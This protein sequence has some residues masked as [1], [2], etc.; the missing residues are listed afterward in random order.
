MQSQGVTRYFKFLDMLEAK[1][2]KRI[3]RE[4]YERRKKE[5]EDFD[6]KSREV[7]RR[8]ANLVHPE[9]NPGED[10]GGEDLEGS[11]VDDE[12]DGENDDEYEDDPDFI[13]PDEETGTDGT[14]EAKT[15]AQPT[16]K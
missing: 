9:G 8:Y 10:D 16:A 6:I 3:P 1:H 11:D 2:D 12:D 15:G 14:E 7:H 13:A 5:Y 4:E